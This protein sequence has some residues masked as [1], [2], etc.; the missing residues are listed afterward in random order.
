MSTLRGLG[1]G[2]TRF[3]THSS[4]AIKNP[5]NE[6]VQKRKTVD[7][8]GVGIIAAL[9][10]LLLGV[11]YALYFSNWGI[12]TILEV[13]NNTLISSAEIESKVWNYLAKEKGMLPKNHFFSFSTSKLE[14]K[15]LGDFP[16]QGVSIDRSG[17]NK[18]IIDVTEVDGVATVE[19]ED[20]R[21]VLIDE[22]GK[23]LALH[24][25]PKQITAT[26]STPEG[27]VAPSVAECIFCD[28]S[29]EIGRIYYE[30]IQPKNI[31]IG[32]PVIKKDAVEYIT[33]AL[34][35]FAT[36]DFNPSRVI[37]V[38]LDEEL[39]T[40]ELREGFSVYL[41]PK[42][43]IEQQLTNFNSFMKKKFVKPPYKLEYVDLRYTNRIFYK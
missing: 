2:K 12:V 33:T 39:M 27:S 15:M 21:I 17:L 31:L 29:R 4:I 23:V 26:T 25:I 6:D 30:G 5:F 11:I 7:P 18:L 16:L 13:K 1:G 36:I 10:F 20:K 32:T 28:T 3:K 43:S 42:K 24:D 41:N 38:P 34:R 22:Q 14:S 19:F 40:V 8:R 9:A 35:G 37:Y